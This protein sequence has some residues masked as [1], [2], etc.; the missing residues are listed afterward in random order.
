[1][2]SLI[3]KAHNPKFRYEDLKGHYESCVEYSKRIPKEVIDRTDRMLLEAIDLSIKRFN[4]ADAIY[5]VEGYYLQGRTDYLT[6]R[7]NLRSRVVNSTFREDLR[8]ILKQE[9]LSFMEYA[10]RVMAKYGYDP[11]KAVTR[12]NQFYN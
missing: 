1:M 6:S 9:K 8:A 7:N 10:R 4:R 3:L 11:N 5:N 2:F 12:S